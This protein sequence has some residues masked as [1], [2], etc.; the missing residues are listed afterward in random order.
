MIN[1]IL[2]KYLNN[3]KTGNISNYTL[4]DVSELLH[5]LQNPH[6]KFKTIHIAG[7]NGKGSTAFMLSSILKKSGY[8]TGLYTSPHLIKI[9]ERIKINL[10][11]IT[12]SLLLKHISFIDSV[13]EEYKLMPTYFDI[14]TAVALNY[15][16]D[17]NVDIAVIETGLGGRLDS[18]NIITPELSILTDISI[19]HTNVLGNSIEDITNEKCG[20]IKKGIPVIT[21][22]I[23]SE[24]LNII[25]N[26]IKEKKSRLYAY[27]INFSAQSIRWEN[28]HFIFNYKSEEYSLY[29]IKLKLFPIHQI[30]NTSVV[31]ASL[32]FLKQNGFPGI[33][34][35]IIYNELEI[36]SVPGR[37]QTLNLNPLIVYDPAHNFNAIKNLID[38]LDEFYSEKSKTYI[39]SMMR[40]KADSSTLNLFKNKKTIFYLLN[41][42]RA[43]IPESG[44]FALLVNNDNI[45]IDILKKTTNDTMIIFTGTFRIYNSAINI[46][47]Q[48][49]N[50]NGSSG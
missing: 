32:S 18:T 46:V 43:Y 11:D 25:K 21:S 22:N 47:K 8:K 50:K 2:K 42:E 5:Y 24:V 15:F 10:I 23:D 30:K 16:N 1:E 14:L 4:R 37:F 7:T 12:D 34:D 49:N 39:I 40:D 26:H 31:L 44:E 19:D 3:E 28:N 36:L 29:D 45:I 41:D 38:G 33:A 48:F 20:I 9:N 6:K 13:V 27:N 35:D 17:E